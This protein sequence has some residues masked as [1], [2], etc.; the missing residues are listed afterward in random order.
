M[1]LAD[2]K[3]SRALQSGAGLGLVQRAPLFK[4]LGVLFLSFAFISGCASQPAWWDAQYDYRNGGSSAGSSKNYSSSA[5]RNAP[6]PLPRPSVSTPR[7]PP[8]QTASRSSGTYHVVKRGETV[9]RISKMHGMQVS[10][11]ASL[12]GLDSSYNIE[13]GQKLRLKGTP[14]QVAAAYPQA[15]PGQTGTVSPGAPRPYVKPPLPAPPPPAGGFIW[16]AEGRVLSSFGS[17]EGGLHNDGINIAVPEGTPVRAAQSGVVAYVGNELKGYGNLVLV[18]HAD[19]WMTAY[20]HNGKILAK[21]GDKVVKGQTIALSGQ[22][23]SVSTPQIHFEVR[24]GTKPVDP[25][26]IVRA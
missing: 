21:R 9:Y 3:T 10:E 8:A 7:R 5:R 20:A 12:N 24:K 16:P 25:K 14:V 18:R 6:S 1:R 26:R 23:G 4:R 19:G 13:V 22:S 2:M 17:K 15:R 11:L